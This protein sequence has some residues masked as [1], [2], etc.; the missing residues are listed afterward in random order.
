MKYTAPVK[1]MQFLLHEVFQASL[2][3]EEAVP[4]NSVN[5]ELADT[6]LEEAARITETL[7][8]PLNQSGD[9][10]GVH[11]SD[12][13]VT[14]PKGFKEAWDTYRASGWIG[15]A[16]NPEYGGQGMPKI[17]TVL[18]EEMLHSASNAFAL[19]SILTSGAALALDAHGSDAL[20]QQYLP[21][22]YSG[23]W[24]GVMCLTEAH[25]GS[26]LGIIRTKA[27]S[28]ED[29]SYTISGSKI[30]ITGGEQDLTDNIVH[31]VLAKLP[32]AP[33]GAKGISMFL[34]P[35][36]L[37]NSDGSL[38]ARNG[39]S[40]GSVEEKMGI[41][42]SATCVMN[43]DNAKGWLVGELNRGL[44]CMFT[45]MNYE[46]VSVGLQ[47]LGCS[48]VSY[49][50]A[51]L[52]AQERLQGKAAAIDGTAPIIA[53]A[54][55]R[56]MLMIQKSLIEAG[57][58]FALYVGQQLDVSKYGE[59]DKKTV[60]EQKV[61]LLTP[62]AKAFL[63]DMG[64]ECCVHGQQVFGGH[65]YIREAGMEQ[66]VRDVRISQI[67]EGTNGI[68]AMDLISRKVLANDGLWLYQLLTEIK[69][70]LNIKV[71]DKLKSIQSSVLSSVNLLEDIT[72]FIVNESKSDGDLAGN[73]AVDYLHMFGYVMYGWMW[74]KMAMAAEK[75]LTDNTKNDVL[76]FEA[77]IITA[78]FYCDKILPRLL[79]L[80]QSI[81]AGSS[82]TRGLTAQQF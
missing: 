78:T 69:E 52:Y 13:T 6:V 48:A 22:M 31:L 81:K 20:K 36:F 46:R 1:D 45:M 59:G 35:K 2:F 28:N 41:H 10:E 16:G 32:D 55:V 57:R 19:Y 37:P 75:S 15:L 29:D 76:W 51:L 39:V 63:T 49:E 65:G 50:N 26:D 3:W 80:N 43:F 30:F 66:L 21:K 33:E 40:C 71:S 62:I 79:G 42:A 9:K 82:V 11:W 77:K 12:G 64:L 38:G 44:N 67:Y 47:G 68:Q 4:L 24:A 53:H 14:T 8:A 61:A 58:A 73:C 56:R 18:F 23:E 60:A 72:E 5:R 34:V 54:D 7:V 27:E 74:Y 70:S 25:A 17:L